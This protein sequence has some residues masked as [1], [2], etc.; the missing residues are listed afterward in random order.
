[1]YKNIKNIN[2]FSL[3]FRQLVNETDLLVLVSIVEIS[4]AYLDSESNQ[5]ILFF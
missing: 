5:C 3:P 1:M 4:S 2:P